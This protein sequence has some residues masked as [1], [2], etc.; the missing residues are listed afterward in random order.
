MPAPR[1]GSPVTTATAPHPTTITDA[2][3][4]WYGERWPDAVRLAAHLTGD[5]TAAED[6]ASEVLIRVWRRWE[7]AGWP[8]A[9]DAYLARAVR[10]AVTSSFR[11]RVRERELVRRLAD[12]PS[13][14]PAPPVAEERF[15][16][17]EVAAALAAL[18]EAQRTALTL[19]YLDDLSA[20]EVARRLGIRP[21]SVRSNL[22]RGRRRLA[23]VR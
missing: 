3:A 22:H 14:P 7:V 15:D 13:A 23:A 11:R 16:R 19:F 21:A 9:P 1:E 5:P 2:F 8:D 20:T 18:P 6:I 17:D 10:N 12:E 4:T